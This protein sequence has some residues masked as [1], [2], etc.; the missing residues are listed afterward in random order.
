MLTPKCPA[1]RTSSRSW[2]LRFNESRTSGGSRDREQKAVAV[3]A[4]VTEPS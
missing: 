2:P 1:R 3:I 4:W